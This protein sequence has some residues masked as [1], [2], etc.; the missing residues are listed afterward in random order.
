MSH[1]KI[2][3]AARARM[4]R[5]GEPY[6]AARRAV[7]A[8]QRGR[9]FAISF[10]SRGLNWITRYGDALFG[11][12]PGRSGV[13]VYPDHLHIRMGVFRL[14]VPVSS[15][16]GVK[17]STEKLHG[18]TGVHSTRKGRLLINGCERG[19]VE[20][21]VDPPVKRGKGF[22][23]L[24]P[25]PAARRVILSLENPAEFIEALASPNDVG[26]APSSI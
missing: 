16:L 1:D 21:E 6:T 18:T 19:L 9:F 23:A 25:R 24:I 17:P 2:K 14:D 7:V 20:F 8:E 4:A 5:T 3:A 11:G 10:D 13:F 26:T 22:A 15:I 12:G